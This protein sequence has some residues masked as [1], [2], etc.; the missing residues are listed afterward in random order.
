MSLMKSTMNFL[1]L[2]NTGLKDPLLVISDAHKDL[3]KA[4]T[5]SCAE[6]SWQCC[7]VYSQRNIQ[8]HI[9]HNAKKNFTSHL[10]QIWNQPDYEI[11][12]TKLSEVAEN[13]SKRFPKTIPMLEEGQ[14]DL[15]SFYYF[16]DLVLTLDPRKIASTNLLER[17]ILEVRRRTEKVRIFTSQESYI[18]LVSSQII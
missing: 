16:S 13:F 1:I 8:A 10:K 18:R 5:K 9:P 17:L 7:K 12:K 3:V 2:Y 11:T 4:I 14:E 6:C 15:L